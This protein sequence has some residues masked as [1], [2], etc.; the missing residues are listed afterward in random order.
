MMKRSTDLL[1]DLRGSLVAAAVVL[2]QATAFGVTAFGP[3]L[4]A[5]SG[6]LTGLTGAIL[7]LLISGSVGGAIGLISGP[8]GPS[9]ALLVG[10]AA[11]LTGSGLAPAAIA[12]ALFIVTL[13]A[14]LLQLLIAFAGG[15]RLMKY[16]PYPVIAGLTTGTGLL[17]IR[18]QLN[19][20][21]GIPHH[22][23]WSGWHWLPLVV[24]LTAFVIARYASRFLPGIPGPIVGLL[25]GT[26]L[27]QL[28]LALTDLPAAPP[29][30]VIGALPGLTALHS[31]ALTPSAIDWDALPWP[32]LLQAAFALAV[33]SSLN[34]LLTAVLADTA[35]GQRHHAA[36][37]LRA[38]AIGQIA[39]GLLGGMAGSASVNGTMTAVQAGARRWAPL[40]TGLLLLGL[41]LFS[42]PVSQWLP[43]SALAGIIVASALNLVEKDIL[44]WVRRR[45][46]RVDAA[47]ALLVTG[48]TVGYD[49]MIAVLVGLAIAILLFI[50][51]QSRVPVIHRRLTAVERPSVRQRPVEQ[52]ELLARHGNR[53][54]LYQLRGILFFAKT[55]QLF[56]EMLPDLDRP[57]WVI[58]HLRRVIQ[59]D[60]SSVRLLQQIAARLE[61][62]GGELLFCDVREDLGLGRDVEQTLRRISLRSGR[63]N[64]QTFAS[65]DQ[66]LEYAENALLNTLGVAPTVLERRIDLAE[67]DLCRDMSPDEITAFAAALQPRELTAGE[68]LFA[69]GDPGVE[70]YLVLRGRVDIRLPSTADRYKRLAIYG[71][72]TVFGEIAFLDPGPRAAE[73]VAVRPSELRVLHR[74]DFNRLRDMRPGVAIALLLALGR[75]QSRSLRWSA[76]EIQQLIQW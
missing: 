56:E 19:P 20:L 26:A 25:G 71:P 46:T 39:V 13:L 5:A 69:A 2:P 27:F 17:M 74:H 65:T 22:G 44:A 10:T 62:H 14:G 9:M 23:L 67:M 53:I 28:M 37:E 64:V 36:R 75:L 60:L 41:L 73:A 47:V 6:A 1:S 4:G 50:R 45:Q 61:A 8:S 51:A 54:I 21:L 11:L 57:A 63:L 16:I 76:L 35:T 55:D 59:I 42:G 12:P 7:L 52:A 40:T 29:H 33:L 18:S 30:W 24:A 34:T 70:L 3:W 15:G 66:A 68:R 58:L 48:V 72:G 49:L 32:L 38:Q 43:T 31:L